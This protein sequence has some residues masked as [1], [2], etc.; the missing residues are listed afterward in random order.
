MD[1]KKRGSSSSSSQGSKKRMSRETAYNKTKAKARADAQARTKRAEQAAIASGQDN[2]LVRKSYTNTANTTNR[3]SRQLEKTRAII[4]DPHPFR[5]KSFNDRLNAVHLSTSTGLTSGRGSTLAGLD[6]QGVHPE[7]ARGQEDQEEDDDMDEETRMARLQAKTAFGAAIQ[8]WRELNLTVPFQTLLRKISHQSQSLTLLIHHREHIVNALATTLQSRSQADSHLAYEPCLDLF[9]RLALDLH[10]EFLPVYT[11][12]LDAMLTSTMIN[13]N[14]TSGDEQAAAR[15]VEKGFESIAA[16]FRNL[17]QLIVKADRVHDTWLIVRPYLGWHQSK[18]APHQQ[19][20]KQAEG[21]ESHPGTSSEHEHSQAAEAAEGD[22]TAQTTSSSRR[23]RH[24]PPHVRRFAAEALAHL[25][26]RCKQSQLTKTAQAMMSDVT[27]MMNDGDSSQSH[28]FATSV[29]AVWSEMIKGVD[30]RLH[31]QCQHQLA[32]LLLSADEQQGET[33]A[34]TLVGTLLVTSLV[35]HAQSSHLTPLYEVLLRW[36]NERLTAAESSTSKQ[37]EASHSLLQSVS[38]LTA[39]VG[40]RKGNRVDDGIKSDLFTFLLR[41]AKYASSPNT[42]HALSASTVELISFTFP[43]GRIPDL[44]GPGMKIIDALSRHQKDDT[45]LPF[46]FVSTVLSLAQLSTTWSSNF[47]QFVLPQVMNATVIALEKDNRGYQD[48]AWHL[49][50]KLVESGHIT[51]VMQSDQVNT[52]T[53]ARWKR[54]VAKNLVARVD[55]SAS[56]LAQSDTF[57]IEDTHI[58]ALPLVPFFQDVAEQLATPLRGSISSLSR[59]HLQSGSELYDA[60]PLNPAMLLSLLSASLAGLIQAVPSKAQRQLLG[61]LC[62]DDN[63][64]NTIIKSLSQH[65]SALQS[66]LKLFTVSLRIESTSVSLPEPESIAETFY[67][68][69]MSEDDE[70]RQAAVGW[71]SL[72]AERHSSSTAALYASMSTI[73]SIPLRV[74]TVRDRNVR[75]RSLVRDLIKM[76][77]S[78]E[79]KTAAQVVVRYV[80]GTLKLN[81]KPVWEESR[82]ALAD[83]V[84]SSGLA[85]EIWKVAFEE[86]TRVRLAAQLPHQWQIPVQP[87]SSQS[88]DMDSSTPDSFKDPQR[89]QRQTSIDAILRTV[90]QPLATQTLTTLIEQQKPLGR[91]DTANYRSQILTLFSELPAIVEKHNAQFV[92]HFF[93]G[94]VDDD[95]RQSRLTGDD[96]DE[97]EDE[98][99]TEQEQQNASSSVGPRMTV[100]ERQERLCSY[101]QVFN[102]F[103]NP[104]ALFRSSELHE[105]FYTLVSSSTTRLQRLGLECVFTWKDPYQI[106][107][108]ES[109]FRLLDQS[110][111]REE[112]ASMDLS[113]ESGKSIQSEH[114]SSVVPLLVRVLFGLAISRKG[115][116]SAATSG[117]GKKVAILN[118]LSGCSVAELG[119]LV[120]LMLAPLEDQKTSIGSSPTPVAYAAQQVGFLA[121]LADVIKHI[122]QQ[123]LPFWSDLITVTVNLA[124]HASLRAAEQGPGKSSTISRDIRQSGIRRIADFF[125]S[126]GS[127]SDQMEHFEWKTYIPVIFSTLISPRL[128]T[129][130]SENTQSPSAL[131]ELFIVWSTR[132]ET[133][134]LLVQGDERLLPSLYACLAA[135]S[136]KNAVVAPILD[137]VERLL[138]ASEESADNEMQDESAVSLRKAITETVLKPHI[139]SLVSNL[140]PAVQRAASTN[141][142]DP[143]L[144]R[145]I[146]LVARLAVFV[147][148]SE[149]ATLVLDLLGPMMRKSN[150]IVPEKSKSDL[151]ATFRDLLL[152][153]DTFQDPT[154]ELFS[155]YYDLFSSM[156]STLRSR[157]A[158]ANLGGVFQQISQVDPQLKRVA[159]WVEKLNA[160]SEKRLDEVDFDTR[161]EVF[162]L[163][164]A[165]GQTQLT[166]REW[167]PIVH[168]MLFFIQD[169]EEL[170][171]RTNANAVLK[172]FINAVSQDTTSASEGED[173]L[174][175]LFNRSV[176]PALRRTLKAKSEQVRREVIN[177]IGHAVRILAASGDD[178]D[179]QSSLREMQG[180]LAGGDEEA[181]FFNNIHH[182]QLHRRARAL[183]RLGDHAE[184]GAIKS[185][186]LSEVLL[187]LI[188]HFIEDGHTEI[189]DHNLTNETVTCIGRLARQLAWGSYNALLWKYL[190]AA[191][192]KGKS[193]KVFVRVAMAILD[194][195]HFAMDEVVQENEVV[196]EE[197]E[198]EGDE[199]VESPTIAGHAADAERRQKIVT[200][201]TSKLLPALMG[202]LEHHDDNTDDAI[203]LP[204]AV[205][206]VRV[207]E[208]LPPAEKEVQLSKL[209]N[210]LSNVFRSKS[211]ETRDLARETL[212]K[213][214][215][216]LGSERL[217]QIVK[218]M[219]R[220]LTRGPQLAVLAYNVHSVLVHLMQ[221]DGG[222][223]GPLT[224]LE[225]A[226]GIDDIVQIASEDIFGHTAEDRENVEYKSKQREMRSS[227][228]LD[229]FE[230]LA[231][232]I[233]PHRINAM[234]VPLKNVMTETETPRAM[235]AVEDALRRIA[236]GINANDHFDYTALLGLCYSLISRN[237]NFLTARKGAAKGVQQG[238]K[239][240]SNTMQVDDI[241]MKRK[242]VE[243]KAAASR[244]DH[245]AS[246]AYRFVSFG[247]DLLVTALRRSRFDFASGDVLSRLDP[248]VNV[249]GNTLYSADS[250]VLN[251]GLRAAGG[252]LRCP[253]PSL[254]QSLPIFVR[255]T[256]QIINREANPASDASQAGLRTLTIMLRD[257]PQAEFKEKQL[258]DL[259]SLCLPEIEEPQA[260]ASIFGLL[261]AILARRFVVVEVYDVMDKVA[262]MLVTNQ[263]SS[264]R[265]SCRAI[266]LQFLLDYPQGKGRLKNQM[267]FLA[268]NL[269]YVFESGRLSVMELLTA[270]MAKFSDDILQEY[271][272]LFFVALVMVLANDDQTRCREKAA[273][274]GKALIGLVDEERRGRMIG[275]THSWA[276]AHEEKPDLARVGLQV[277]GLIVDSQNDEGQDEAPGWTVQ[278][279]RNARQVLTLCADDLEELESSDSA[280]AGMDVDMDLDWQLA[281]HGLQCVSKLG[282]VYPQLLSGSKS[283]PLWSS[284]RRLLL[285]PH[286]WVRISSS[287]LMGHLFASVKP[288][289][290]SIQG[291]S[292]EDPLSRELLVDTAKKL[293]LQLKGGE[294]RKVDEKLCLQIVKNLLWIARSFAAVQATPDEDADVDGEEDEEEQERR[295]GG[296][297]GAL[298]NPL[299]WLLT[300]LSYQARTLQGAV[301]SS[302]N[303]SGISS[304]SPTSILRLFAALSQH[305]STIQLATYL[306]HMITPLYRSMTN[307]TLSGQLMVDLK[308]LA[309][310]VQ[311]LLSEKVGS[312][313]YSS[314]YS[315][316]RSKALEKRRVRK[317]KESM[318]KVV[319]GDEVEGGE[320]KRR[321]RNEAKHLSR[322]RKNAAFAG[323]KVRSRPMKR[324]REGK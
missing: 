220:S 22:N 113:L 76:I 251:L 223:V 260:Q 259:L 252:L 279:I 231:K 201:V 51:D 318:K 199:A 19:Q 167:Q 20:H 158:R 142:P 135:P 266:F 296:D 300:K 72:C 75:L 302:S 235:K 315:R 301:P 148:R 101:L 211:Q 319:N 186:T 209:L 270:V 3:T 247:L 292:S 309:E 61:D 237:A 157:N 16:L 97:D 85:D 27:T 42:S 146:Q 312:S 156:W 48:A 245:Y 155:K 78:E 258:A 222:E 202:Y 268:K 306:P 230:Q 150:K 248:L 99:E 70:L 121:F 169:A 43:I 166:L 131:L 273:E 116:N 174:R 316:I 182:I 246:N 287:R 269:S 244:K 23:R 280:F 10:Q 73:E 153:T 77:A 229:T 267:E 92:Q 185:K 162:D 89:S 254:Q 94:V 65:R 212:C 177:A 56:R 271:S 275:M 96:E 170:V 216:A 171:L 132:D 172:Q 137:I 8:T 54:V 149:D 239:K 272:E 160:F 21:E 120:D 46:A 282:R 145:E 290:P 18:E 60:S 204:I 87:S 41:L 320:E 52:P 241:L 276:A 240:Q 81:F 197:G 55:E 187:P 303:P 190:R 324:F 297:T 310:E 293:S 47:R 304:E 103:S 86:L 110:K 205:G 221:Q 30:R 278:A 6:V 128:T 168:N 159:G 164:S 36:S 26:R 84:G 1:H 178:L 210:V 62:V 98:G 257:C 262:E 215:V 165:D 200:T 188:A 256:L 40:T 104:K 79:V 263:S 88:E 305:L 74:E 253:L 179:Q 307:E 34:Q 224:Y 127:S 161:L 28:A 38:W 181:N 130:A 236:S 152:L 322:K 176:Y 124:H 250:H 226:T 117:A 218:E 232:I 265:E 83:L 193:E 196:A 4:D 64:S 14:N 122:G 225:D 24:I 203:R 180:L 243:Q 57:E 106:P 274:L 11:Q 66:T 191:N 15:I 311:E 2:H 313:L 114:R 299:S 140:A 294:D 227:K 317:E 195:F 154:S 91:L 95:V 119:V 111:F 281:Y 184:T 129:F 175:L 125:R 308:S 255:Q 189:G 25:L 289:S 69:I 108:S 112:L 93:E 90:S 314:V 208:C 115:R 102:K 123:I 39:A 323:D 284:V 151:L 264:V 144:Q 126:P 12:A 285:F 141:P 109:I 219:R 118:A 214:S 37:N 136:V 63:L 147:T 163:L 173:T 133:L 143:L 7:D 17:A 192:A 238:G 213:I 134:P 105:Y 82:K 283:H 228:S 71:L 49:L 35:H 31:S 33:P 13:K 295:Q 277:Y 261:R 234:M 291:S 194:N 249:V 100:K 198:G 207:V 58:C 107:Y 45:P 217:P 138:L 298:E 53:V 50:G 242:D 286:A 68:A 44:V 9:P 67:P 183:R 288:F 233:A 29:A 80:I 59:K 206:V 32:A 321:K 139:S 5:Y